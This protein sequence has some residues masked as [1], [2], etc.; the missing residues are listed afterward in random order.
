MGCLALHKHS[1]EVSKLIPMHISCH[2]KYIGSRWP[3]EWEQTGAPMKETPQG[4]TSNRDRSLPLPSLTTIGGALGWGVSQSSPGF[5][6]PRQVPD[7]LLPLCPSSPHCSP[8]LS[9]LQA[10]CSSIRKA[11]PDLSGTGMATLFAFPACGP[12]LQSKGGKQM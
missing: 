10:A 5:K 12:Q 1:A 6:A 9:P 8:S 2:S 7:I 4:L 11:F 3:H